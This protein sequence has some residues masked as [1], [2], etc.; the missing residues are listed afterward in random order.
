MDRRKSAIPLCRHIKTDGRLCG[1]PAM[2][3]IAFCYFHGRSRRPAGLHPRYRRALDGHDSIQQTLGAI[4]AGTAS[5]DLRPSQAGRMLFAI[6][7]ALSNLDRVPPPP[8]ES[9][10]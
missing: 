9:R 3:G 8:K 10:I 1:S 7:M 6:Q 4:I 2:T 5:G